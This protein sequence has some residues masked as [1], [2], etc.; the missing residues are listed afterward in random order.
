MHEEP[1]TEWGKEALEQGRW[2]IEPKYRLKAIIFED[3]FGNTAYLEPGHEPPLGTDTPQ[4]ARR[5]TFY[6][7]AHADEYAGALE[8]ILFDGR[9]W[10]M[11]PRFLELTKRAVEFVQR[12][13]GGTE[14]KH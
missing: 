11:M 2:A 9:R 7:M 1:E 5:P 14:T 12:T 10:A 8:A 6:G 3:Q 13:E 4:S